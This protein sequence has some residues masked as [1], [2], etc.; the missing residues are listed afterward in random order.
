M[1]LE[2]RGFRSASS[3]RSSFDP[4]TLSPLHVVSVVGKLGTLERDGMGLG[5]LVFGGGLEAD[6]G[7]LSALDHG[8]PDDAEP[9]EG[10]GDS[11]GEVVLRLGGG[12]G[13][14][15]R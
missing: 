13:E 11:S 6:E 12:R 10:D 5:V 7:S 4:H 8:E 3:L 9:E 1:A 14:G 2:G 15:K